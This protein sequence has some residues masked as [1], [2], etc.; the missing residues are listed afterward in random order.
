MIKEKKRSG[1]F[2]PSTIAYIRK[3]ELYATL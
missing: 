2:Y 3:N 1:M